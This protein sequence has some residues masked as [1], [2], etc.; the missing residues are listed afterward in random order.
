[1]RGLI[2]KDIT[3]FFK[4]LDKRL[5]FMEAAMILFALFRT[6]S[7]AGFFTSFMLALATGIQSILCIACDEK[8]GWKKYQRAMPVSGFTVVMSKYLSVLC[9][10]SA[11]SV[12]GGLIFNLIAGIIYRAF[13]P[14]IWLCSIAVT[15][16]LPPLWNA[17]CL[18]LSYWFGLQGAQSMGVL[19]VFPVFFTVKYFEDGPGLALMPGFLSSYALVFIPAAVVLLAISYMISVVGY[20]RKK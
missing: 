11:I 8:I 2:Y 19:M 18:P 14:A 12:L 20:E 17:V 10:A 16:L 4:S 3:I 9:S 1:M 6:G 7:V 5:L 15:L 13:D